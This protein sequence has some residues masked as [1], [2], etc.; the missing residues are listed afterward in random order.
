MSHDEAPLRGKTLFVTRVFAQS[1]SRPD[2]GRAGAPA[3]KAG[4]NSSVRL[5]GGATWAGC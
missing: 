1:T 5:P 2:G 4:D 3:R